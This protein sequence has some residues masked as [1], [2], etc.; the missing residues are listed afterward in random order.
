MK[1]LLETKYI[2]NLEKKINTEF[3]YKLIKSP[4]IEINIPMYTINDHKR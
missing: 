1:G 3:K 2:S 4:K